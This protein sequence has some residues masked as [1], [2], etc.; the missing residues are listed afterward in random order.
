[1]HQPLLILLL[2]VATNA[3]AQLQPA[4]QPTVSK[5][6]N[7][8]ARLY[9]APEYMPVYPGGQQQLTKDIAANLNYPKAAKAAGLGGKIFVGFTVGADGMVRDVKLVEGLTAPAGKE[10]MVRELQDAGL[11]A[12]R[13][14]TIHWTPGLQNNKRVAVYLVQP[15]LLRP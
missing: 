6:Q 13:S 15:L 11:Q 2:L 3:S 1:M 8:D 4:S 14:L 10:S 5:A 7:G 12:V 9:T